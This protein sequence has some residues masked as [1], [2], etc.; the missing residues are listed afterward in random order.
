MILIR[1]SMRMLFLEAPNVYSHVVNND[2]F[3]KNIGPIE[4]IP[5]IRAHC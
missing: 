3:V 2:G 4:A 1:L 5:V